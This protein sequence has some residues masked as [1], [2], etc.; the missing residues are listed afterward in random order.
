MFAI[1]YYYSGRLKWETAFPRPPSFIFRLLCFLLYPLI[2]YAIHY[3]RHKMPP[4]PGGI[5]LVD[6]DDGS[7]PAIPQLSITLL[8]TPM[9]IITSF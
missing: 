4:E 5:L 2:A 1:D 9:A 8:T 3:K 7:L 6:N